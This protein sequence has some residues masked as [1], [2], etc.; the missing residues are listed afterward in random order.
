MNVEIT[1][2][3]L[4][5]TIEAIP[6]KSDVH[7]LLILSAL[8]DA[9]TVIEITRSSEDIDATISCLQVMGATI[10]TEGGRAVVTPIESPNPFPVLD[11]GESGSTLRFLLPVASAVCGSAGFTG[12]GR[13]PERPLSD[14]IEAM[15]AHGVVFNSHKLP[16]EISGRLKSGD[17]ELPG[18]VSSQYVTGLLLALPKCRGLSSLRLSGRLES[19]SY[20]DMT[21]SALNRFGVKIFAS[22]SFY[23]IPGDQKYISPKF[24]KADGDWSNAAYFL[25]SGALNGSIT[26]T[27][28]NLA[29]KQGDKAIVD[30]LS[31]F[32][33]IASASGDAVTI[34]SARLK[35]CH[36]DV[37]DTP[38]LLPVLAAVAALAEGET[39]FSGG[40]RLRLKESDRIC[41]SAAMIRSLGGSVLDT[42]DG[43]I[44]RGGRLPGGV[45]DSFRDHRIVMAAAVAAIRSSGPVTIINAES[46][47][48]SYP[49]FFDDYTKMGGRVNVI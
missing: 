33:A 9:K 21:L 44:V 43:L 23:E 49:A 25:A 17:F 32:G 38:D 39:R 29:S 5:G 18:N 37:S 28:L 10:E 11:C 41:S 13:L 36:I 22:D 46:S 26:V 7:R 35:G 16:L 24:I 4:F 19:S 30:I 1:P 47:A 40:A 34:R 42:A 45:V 8:S 6:S 31:R 2:S 20:V 27:G 15:R 3:P 48:K 12:S 14:L